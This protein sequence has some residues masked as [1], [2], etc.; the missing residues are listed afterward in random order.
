MYGWVKCSEESP[1]SPGYYSILFKNSLPNVAITLK[2]DGEQWIELAKLEKEF[3]E[4]A[5]WCKLC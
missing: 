1:D 2:F 4:P 5:Y 3:N